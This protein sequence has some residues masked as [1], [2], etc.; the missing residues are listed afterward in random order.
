MENTNLTPALNTEGTGFKNY[1]LYCSVND[2]YDKL[3][4]PHKVGYYLDKKT[5]VEWAFELGNNRI[6]TI[7]DYKEDKSIYEIKEWHIGGKNITSEDIEEFLRGVDL[8]S[9]AQKVK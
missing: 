6:I 4:N 5:Q 9:C 7:Y 2:L 3:G 1:Y 8:I